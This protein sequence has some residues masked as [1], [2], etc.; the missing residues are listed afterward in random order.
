MGFNI[1]LP[2]MRLFWVR[3]IIDHVYVMRRKESDFIASSQ[4]FSYKSWVI[5]TSV[6]VHNVYRHDF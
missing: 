1:L 4:G 3:E 6:A 5:N 2:T